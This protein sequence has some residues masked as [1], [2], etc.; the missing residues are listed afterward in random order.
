MATT[1]EPMHAVKPENPYIAGAQLPTSRPLAGPVASLPQGDPSA[2]SFV[3]GYLDDPFCMPDLSGLP[4]QNGMYHGTSGPATGSA[5]PCPQPTSW[6]CAGDNFGQDALPQ[7]GGLQWNAG[8]NPDDAGLGIKQQGGDWWDSVTPREQP[9]FDA[10]AYQT[11]NA[12]NAT[13]NLMMHLES[14]GVGYEYALANGLIPADAAGGGGSVHMPQPRH[15]PPEALLNNDFAYDRQQAYLPQAGPEPTRQQQQHHHMHQQ[16]QQQ[17]QQQQQHHM[18]V[19]PPTTT[20]SASGAPTFR[21]PKQPRAPSSG[22]RYHHAGSLTSPRKVRDRSTSSSSP[23]PT[24]S[25]TRSSRATSRGALKQQR[26]SASIHATAPSLPPPAPPSLTASST[27]SLASAASSSSSSSGPATAAGGLPKL[28]PPH[29]IRKRKSWSHTRRSSAAMSSTM[30]SAALSTTMSSAGFEP[31]ATPDR[32]RVS[33]GGARGAS[34]CGGGGGGNG[35]GF[36]NFTPSDHDFLMTGVAPSGSSKTKARRE[37]EAAERQRRLNEAVM[38][39]V[40]ASGGDLTGLRERLTFG[41]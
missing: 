21:R 1:A 19:L 38:T 37:K 22:A 9:C 34:S 2:M 36:V 32:R 26:R 4:G 16:H 11:E 17:R 40:A 41:V 8:F 35:I 6:L 10:A 25:A 18:P 28:A 30:A 24:Q 33:E 12:K 27:S 23:S 5:A 29:A 31:Y 13:L 7:A 15:P 3:N 39:A 20:P 14:S